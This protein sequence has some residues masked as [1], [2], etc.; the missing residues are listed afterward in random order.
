MVEVF[1]TE[2]LEEVT[3]SVL[4][5]VSIMLVV[6]E[7]FGTELV[8]EVAGSVLV[9]VCIMLVVVPCLRPQ[10]VLLLQLRDVCRQRSVS[11]DL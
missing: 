6:V 11:Q 10:Q 4:V 3:G 7:V 5:V 8:D 9:V 1:G 2:L